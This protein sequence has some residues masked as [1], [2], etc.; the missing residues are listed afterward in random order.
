VLLVIHM[1]A[2]SRLVLAVAVTIDL[3]ASGRAGIS[4]RDV[5]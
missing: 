3:V 1:N 4:H 5:L 2:R